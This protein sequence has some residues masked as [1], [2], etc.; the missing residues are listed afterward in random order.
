LTLA[1]IGLYGLM[2]FG[3]ARRRKEIAIRVALGSARS[4]VVRMVVRDAL[5]LVAAGLAI[6]MPLALVSSRLVA[7]LLVGLTPTDPLT[8][9][10]T[11]VLLLAIGAIGGYTPGR[12]GS[13]VNPIDALRA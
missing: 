5:S 9:G 4:D 2:A 3:V 7:S 1:A 13:K 11:A 12:R 10:L 8:L 6:G